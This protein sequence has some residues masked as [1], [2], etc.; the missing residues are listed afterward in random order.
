M[1]ENYR[2]KLSDPM[3]N[4]NFKSILIRLKKYPKQELKSL[5]EEFEHKLINYTEEKMDER[6]IL[7]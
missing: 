6:R 7:T 1:Y 3:I 5:V 4:D 2:E